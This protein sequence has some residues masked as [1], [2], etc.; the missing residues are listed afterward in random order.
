MIAYIRGRVLDI[1]KDYIILENSGIGYEIIMT[2]NDISKI[3][4]GDILEIFLLNSFSMY[5]GNKMYGFLS[6]EDKELFELIK[7]TIPNTGNSK[8]LDYLNKIQKSV[9]EFKKAVIKGDEKILKNIFGFTSKTSRKIIDFL[10]DRIKDDIDMKDLK[11]VSYSNFYDMAYN[12]LINLGYKSVEAKTAVSE[13]ISE[14]SQKNITLEEI[15]KLSLK[16]LS[17]R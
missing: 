2:K 14:N 16:K 9:N 17:G 8:A 5:E 13:V 10:R 1:S 4:T 15:I 7:I 12:A 3:K 6:K 11:T